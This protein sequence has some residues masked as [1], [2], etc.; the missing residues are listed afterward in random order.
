MSFDIS[1]IRS[2]FEEEPNDINQNCSESQE[3]LLNN[4]PVIFQNKRECKGSRK[5]L[6]AS[7]F[8]SLNKPFKSDVESL[9]TTG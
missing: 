9:N 5:K 8:S 7:E 1:A 3:D 6:H 4:T 2:S